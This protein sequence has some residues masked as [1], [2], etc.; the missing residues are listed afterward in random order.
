[1][2]EKLATEIGVNPEEDKDERG[3]FRVEDDG[4]G[5]RVITLNKPGRLNAFSMGMVKVMPQILKEAAE[6]VKTKVDNGNY[7]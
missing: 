2:A 4:D 3:A 5:V 6:D 1:M 7:K